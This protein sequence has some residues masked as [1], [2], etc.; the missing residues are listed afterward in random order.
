MKKQL[1]TLGVA[2]GI[3]SLLLG[4]TA[5]AHVVVKPAEVPTASFQT[6]TASTP[7]EKDVAVTELKVLMPKGLK[8][9]LPTVKDG[10]RIDVEKDGQGETA[11]VKSITWRGGLIPAG[12]RDDFTFSAQVPA[13]ASNL[14]W[15]AYQTYEGG[16]VVAWDLAQDKQPKKA[17]GSPDFSESG[18][19]SITKLTAKDDA[20]RAP[21]GTTASEWT[22]PFATVGVVLGLAAVFLATRK[23][24]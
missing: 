12:F 24:A 10:W 2:V 15:K 23:K 21:T 8:H 14:E 6:F 7:N 13:D 9:V 20:A 22:L 3:C 18:P 19:F 11:E 5:S 1:L 16:Q 4:G 17:D